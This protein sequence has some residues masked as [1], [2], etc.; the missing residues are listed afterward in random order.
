LTD[1][2]QIPKL[3]E[4]GVKKEDFPKIISLTDIKNHPVSLTETELVNILK[5]RL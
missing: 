1:D 4:Y 2:L 3:S 5:E